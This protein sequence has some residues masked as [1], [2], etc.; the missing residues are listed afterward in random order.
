MLCGEA[1]QR[2]VTQLM[3]IHVVLHGCVSIEELALNRLT[4]TLKLCTHI[5]HVC[6]Y[7]MRAQ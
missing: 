7:T 3:Y 2:P 6:T 5:V 1:V 4:N